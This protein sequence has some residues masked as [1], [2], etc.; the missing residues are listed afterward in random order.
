MKARSATTGHR[1]ATRPAAARVAFAGAMATRPDALLGR[2]AAVAVR[3]R[4]VAT[5]VVRM[6]RIRA[7]RALAF[8]RRA[9][10]KHAPRRLAL[11]DSLHQRREQIELVTR[12]AAAAVAH[13]GHE[14][15]AAGLVP[16]L[17]PVGR[18]GALVVVQRVP[19]REP[20]I[21][22]AVVVDHFAAATDEGA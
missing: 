11:L 21:A 3:R 22:D 12:R 4:H 7:Q 10:R 2:P 14:V 15:E 13:A 19:G 1:A 17:P 5:L 9:L 8:H 18:R 20:R 6:G 16:G